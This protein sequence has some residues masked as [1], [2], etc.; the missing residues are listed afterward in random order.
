MGAES[1]RVVSIDMGK[2]ERTW[3]EE[4]A[5]RQRDQGSQS[6]WIECD[7][8]SAPIPTTERVDN[9]DQPP[10][11]L[12]KAAVLPVSVSA[13]PGDFPVS[14]PFSEGKGL[15]TAEEGYFVQID[16]TNTD[17]R[18]NIEL[19]IVKEGRWKRR[20]LKIKKL[21]KGLI[22]QW[23]DMHLDRQ[24]SVL[25]IITEVNGTGSVNL[26][27]EELEKRQVLNLHLVR[28]DDFDIVQ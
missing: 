6:G 7:V 25:D 21:R 28:P 13:S 23:N 19:G 24:V 11:S 17:A 16:T 10:C 20:G 12:R 26:M 4:E 9:E 14:I 27:F 15:E 8:A 5:L 1:D 18:I 22:S 2:L 3:K